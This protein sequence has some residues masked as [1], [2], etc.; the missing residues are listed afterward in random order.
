LEYRKQ[1][2][3]AKRLEQE[4]QTNAENMNPA[5]ILERPQPN[6]TRDARPAFSQE[7]QKLDLTEGPNAYP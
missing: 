4:L 2:M 3:I 1:G 7:E 5:R 6:A